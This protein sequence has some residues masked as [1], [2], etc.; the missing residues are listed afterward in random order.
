VNYFFLP[1][2]LVSLGEHVCQ[3]VIGNA[4]G[5][6]LTIKLHDLDVHPREKI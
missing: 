1:G 5:P 2:A 4:P 6:Q 3:D